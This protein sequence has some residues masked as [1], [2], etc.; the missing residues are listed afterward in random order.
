MTQNKG[1]KLGGLGSPCCCSTAPS[2]SPACGCTITQTTLTLTIVGPTLTGTCFDFPSG[3][4]TCTLTLG[5]PPSYTSIANGWF[6]TFTGNTGTGVFP[7]ILAIMPTP[8]TGCNLFFYIV[9][10]ESIMCQ[11]NLS[12]AVITCSPLNIVFSYSGG[13]SAGG[14]PCFPT[15]GGGSNCSTV[16][17]TITP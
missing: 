6:G 12:F 9:A 11:T 2:G 8:N 4:T 3:T 17:F 13:S 14:S 10:T 16:T 5:T 1:F 15:V 7:T